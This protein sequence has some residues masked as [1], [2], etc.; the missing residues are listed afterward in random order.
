MNVL[1]AIGHWPKV[2]CDL[3]EYSITNTNGEVSETW[4]KTAT[5]NAWKWT[6]STSA[7]DQSGK[8]QIIE[9]HRFVFDPATVVNEDGE[10]FDIT[11]KLK[12]VVDSVDYFITGKDNILSNDQVQVLIGLRDAA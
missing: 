7:I 12:I 11:N 8:L 5:V 3:Y 4:T 1:T 2:A 10:T 9:S 6:E